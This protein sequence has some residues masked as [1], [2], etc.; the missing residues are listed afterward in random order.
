MRI[1]YGLRFTKEDK[2]KYISHL[3]VLRL[4]Q[5]AFKRADIALRHSEGFNPHPKMSF[6]QPL[7][8][9]FTSL[10]EYLEFETEDEWDNQLLIDTL[11]KV[12]PPGISVTECGKL[13]EA[14]R[15]SLA[16]LIEGADYEI[17]VI[18]PSGE[19]LAERIPL[20]L[21][22]EGIFIEKKRKKDKNPTLVDVKP[23]IV[24]LEG[25]EDGNLLV[26][27]T[28]LKTGSNANLNPDLLLTAFLNFVNIPQRRENISIERKDLLLLEDEAYKSLSAYWA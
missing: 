4:F 3:D 19:G 28:R 5:R 26:L 7:S 10:G 27:D 6:A 11:N 13:P 12:L 2:L 23:L 14:P 24:S 15:K 9:G 8:L 25:R 16:S 20:F 18:I 22:Q 21:E 1:L 17:K